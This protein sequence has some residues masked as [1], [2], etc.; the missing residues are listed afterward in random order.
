MK[1]FRALVLMSI[2]AG[3]ANAKTIEVKMLNNGVDGMMVF[4]PAFVKADIGDTIKFVMTDPAHASSS[5]FTPEGAKTWAGEVNQEVT[6]I[7]DKEGVYIYECLP[8]APLAMIGV[9]QAGGAPNLDK[10]MKFATTYSKKFAANG[11]RLDKY[12]AMAGANATTKA[13]YKAGSS[14]GP[15][16]GAKRKKKR[17][18]RG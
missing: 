4:E 10:A 11:E 14:S 3:I 2:F 5:V 18:K 15:K 1:P 8:H 13:G 7:V 6:T 16:D 12:L 17:K 9:I